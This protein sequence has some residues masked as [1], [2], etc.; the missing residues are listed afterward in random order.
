MVSKARKR[1]RGPM[2]SLESEMLDGASQFMSVDCQNAY[3][4]GFELA[5]QL[6]QDRAQV[7]VDAITDC[8]ISEWLD[9]PESLKEALESYKKSMETK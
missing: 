3:I 1:N 8:L 7:L 4:D 2:K 6:M 5:Q 9:K